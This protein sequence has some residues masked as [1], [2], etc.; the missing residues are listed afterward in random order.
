MM[1]SVFGM[2]HLNYLTNMVI[3]R[4]TVDRITFATAGACD[5]APVDEFIV[6]RSV[7]VFAWCYVSGIIIGN[8]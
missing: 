7:N 4:L 6:L 2:S 5:H 1:A 8:A 3:K